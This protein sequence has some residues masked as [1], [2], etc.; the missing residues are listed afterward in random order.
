MHTAAIQIFPKRSPIRGDWS[1]WALT[2][3]HDSQ[4]SQLFSKKQKEPT[5]ICIR[6]RVK[7]RNRTRIYSRYTLEFELINFFESEARAIFLLPFT[8]IKPNFRVVRFVY[9]VCFAI[10][11]THRISNS[12]RRRFRDFSSDT[13]LKAA[14]LISPQFPGDAPQH[15]KHPVRTSKN[16]DDPALTRRSR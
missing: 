11:T 14:A 13:H 7:A 2:Q 3:Q 12:I 6:V 9:S 15:A 8:R 4:P 10:N 5:P 16:V 1:Y